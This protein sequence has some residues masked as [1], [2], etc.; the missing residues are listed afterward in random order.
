[1]QKLPK[2][3]LKW[4]MEFLEKLHFEQQN[5]LDEEE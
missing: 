1:M 5:F 3:T 4:T 2:Y